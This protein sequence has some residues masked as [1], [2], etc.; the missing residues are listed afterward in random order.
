MLKVCHL[1]GF[2]IRFSLA[3]KSKVTISVSQNEPC[4]LEIVS[5]CYLPNFLWEKLT[6]P[7][8]I[9]G[10]GLVLYLVSS[11]KD[12]NLRSLED[13]GIL[14]D[15]WM[16][17]SWIWIFLTTFI[18]YWFID[19]N[20]LCLRMPLYHCV[21]FQSPACLAWAALGRSRWSW[22]PAFH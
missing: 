8:N 1:Y 19:F 11:S 10:Q 6:F 3:R 2:I 7:L 14:F 21:I 15:F 5:S 16:I 4:L 18:C 12:H 20:G 17:D 13:F 22:N 9:W